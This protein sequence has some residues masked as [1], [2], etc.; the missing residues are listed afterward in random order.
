[1][2][3][4]RSTFGELAAAVSGAA[5]VLALLFDWYGREVGPVEGSLSGWRSLTAIDIALALIGALAAL[6]WVARG[7]GW[8]DRRPW[9]LA[10]AAVMA[11]LG[12]IAFV[13]V[14]VRIVDLPDAAAAA[15]LD[16]RR[17]GTFLALF[18]AGGIVLGATAALGARGETWRPGRGARL[19]RSPE[20]TP[21]V[22]DAGGGP[23]QP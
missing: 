4:G 7:S 19:A 14:C 5:M 18:A 17:V 22:R 6:H 12:V 3:T 20:A 11:A 8:L 10:P 9:P 13:L 2:R 16:G 15:G 1:M 21:V 23:H